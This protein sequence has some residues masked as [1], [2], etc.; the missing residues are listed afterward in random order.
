[1]CT[2]RFSSLTSL[3]NIKTTFNYSDM[4][5]YSHH[6]RLEAVQLHLERGKSLRGLQKEYGISRQMITNW[7]KAYQEHGVEGLLPNYR[8]CGR[9]YSR[10]TEVIEK[11]KVYKK[12]HPKWGA[13][14][15]LIKLADDFPLMELPTERYLQ[16]IFQTAGLQPQRSR[17]PHH[18]GEWASKAF[19]RVQVDAK[20][21]LKTADGKPCCYLNFT[22]EYT[23]SEL[24][25]F[26]FSLRTNL[27]SSASRSIG[28]CNQGTTTVGEN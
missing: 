17:L 12:L 22:D 9:H 6:I 8:N 25:A 11:A 27:R 28:L 1:M 4:K 14:F 21:R 20:E 19:D 2:T 26:F 10:F 13:S 15:I 16:E 18:Q 23:G 3:V 5:A 24:D 7:V